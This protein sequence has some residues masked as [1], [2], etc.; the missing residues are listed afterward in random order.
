MQA[1]V[2]RGGANHDLALTLAFK[3]N[4]DML[5]IQEP[6]IYADLDR[7]STKTHPGFET[8]SPLTT[9]TNRP[10]VMTYVRKGRGLRPEQPLADTSRDVLLV[11]LSPGNCAMPIWNIYNA[12][13]GSEN[14]GEGLQTLLHLCRQP[15][16]LVAGD[17]NIR[18]SMWDST[19][20]GTPEDGEDLLTWAETHGLRIANPADTPTHQR[21]GTL[22]LS[23]VAHPSASCVV[24]RLLHTTSDHESLLTTVPLSQKGTQRAGRLNYKECDTEKF[25]QLLQHAAEPTSA[26]VER[27]AS[28]IVEALSTALRG[29][30]K[31][32]TESAKGAPWWDEACK[33]ALQARNRL[34]QSGPVDEESRDL[35]ACVRRAKRAY[36]QKV[37]R[38]AGTLTDVYK[39]TKWHKREA[40]FQT[41]PLQGPEGLGTTPQ[42][43]SRILQLALLSRH[44]EEQDIPPDAPAVPV[45]EIPW[46]EISDNEVF[47]ATC[48]V[49][50]TS[51]GADECTAAMLK[52][53]WP[54]IGARITTLFRRLIQEGVHPKIF[55]HA[56]TVILP[57]SGRRDRS[58][59]N[60]YR[61]IAL[62]SCM[63]KGLER[64][65]ARRL[66]FSALKLKILAR[67]QCSA[68]SRRSATDLTTAL[69]ADVEKAWSQK[70]VAGMVTVDVK[71]AFDGVLGNR[72]TRRL[73]EQGW[74][75]L[76]VR[77]IR[78]FLSERTACIHLDK[79]RSEAFPV[80]CGL[81]QG[82]PIS[83]ILFLLYVEPFLRLSKGRFGYADDGSL[84]VTGK[85]VQEVNT[86]LQRQLDLTFA[87]GRENGVVFDV[88][89]TELQYFHRKR[90][91]SRD[92][93]VYSPDGTAIPPNESTRWLGVHFD[94]KMSF[95][96]HVRK[97]CIRARAITD[98]INRLCRTVQGAKPGLVR[99]AVQ[100]CAFATLFYGAETWYGR[101]TS[102][103]VLT[104]IQR[105]INRAARA[106]LPVYKTTP[107]PILLRETGWAP[108]LVWLEMIH[109]RCVAR[110]A[111]ADSRHP[112]RTRWDS[113][114]IRW[115]RRRQEVQLSPDFF[116]PPWD[117][118]DRAAIKVQIGACGRES[119]P[120][121]FAKWINERPA[122]DLIVYS[123]GSKNDDGNAGAGFCV[124]RGQQELV[125][126]QV[127]L[128]QTAEVYDAEIEGALAGI[129]A[130]SAHLMAR[131]ATRVTVCLDNEEAAI[132][133]FSGVPTDSS[134][135]AILDFQA[136]RLAW[137]SRDRAGT[138]APGAVDIR[139]CPAHVGIAGNEIADQLAKAAC[140][141]ATARQSTTIARAKLLL[142]QRYEAAAKSYWQ[143]HCPE[144]YARLAIEFTTRMPTELFL[145]RPCL[146]RILAARSGHGDFAAY[147]ERFHHDEAELF[148]QCGERKAPDHFT[149]CMAVNPSFTR[150]AP[151][152]CP[153]LVQWAL[154]TK[155]GVKAFSKWL[156]DTRFFG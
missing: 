119:G 8:F 103:T 127:P 93:A 40:I 120:A 145:S 12:P 105:A 89:K 84:L 14:A 118:I 21:G 65:L 33:A 48:R 57:K 42:E 99:Q 144:R 153:D 51:P 143:E 141:M 58:L 98:H 45:R 78:S 135:A 90:D 110:T 18:H 59:P 147:H 29:S 30:C 3:D 15:P 83:P 17:F 53:A 85:T 9:W 10:R 31:R 60:S 26:E 100:G 11:T 67:N 142:K 34:R 49:P 152:S 87:W 95:K 92:P 134:A 124:Y 74:P 104:M 43:K 115:M 1:N 136:S 130:A 55:K 155:A 7:R 123:D 19:T 128:G 20:M 112:L 41:P 32:K 88:S 140:Q 54:V 101:S 44:L 76:L 149:N 91:A 148:C 137:T 108:A 81:P 69:A 71:G 35:K 68:V 80:L 25:L 6:W 109:D 75:D 116:H 46:K 125:R 122:L 151:P 62:L 126:G 28:D 107:I 39:I 139:W 5:L 47:A 2:G 22:D 61:P 121:A 77:W 138:A 63:G 72:L 86:R 50:S 96:E 133:L 113:P 52:V 64:L 146:G 114:R 111:A 73:R 129:R 16:T 13:Y 106:V 66:T 102:Q 132:R 38:D 4:C 24:A 27:E 97:A 150:V 36:W 94:R 82:S 37:V 131:F 70:L 154:A 117:D 56:E 23:L 156:V 79:T